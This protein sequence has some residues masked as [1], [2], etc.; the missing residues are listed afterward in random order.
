MVSSAAIF[1]ILSTLLARQAFGKIQVSQDHDGIC[2]DARVILTDYPDEE[3][4]EEEERQVHPVQGFLEVV[5][6]DEVLYPSTRTPSLKTWT[7]SSWGT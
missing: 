2:L 6:V 5:F 1:G 7:L 3:E 4:E